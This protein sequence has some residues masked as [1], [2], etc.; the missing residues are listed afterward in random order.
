MQRVGARAALRP[1]VLAGALEQAPAPVGVA[2]RERLLGRV[3]RVEG[4]A[5]PLL[6]RPLAGLIGEAPRERDALDRALVRGEQRDRARRVRLGERRRLLDRE[7]RVDGRPRADAVADHR[8]DPPERGQR[9]PRPRPRPQP[10]VE[11]RV[12]GEAA[13]PLLPVRRGDRRRHPLH[14][15]RRLPLP[16]LGRKLVD[17]PP[18]PRPIVVG[19]LHHERPLV[20]RQRRADLPARALP[21]R[22]PEQA[23]P[24]VDLSPRLDRPRRA[25]RRL[26]LRPAREDRLRP[27]R[28]LR[29]PAGGDEP[30][31]LRLVRRALGLPQLR[32]LL[33]QRPAGRARPRPPP[34]PRAA[35]GPPRPCPRARARSARR[36][37]APPP[38]AAPPRGPPTRPP[39]PRPRCGPPRSRAAPGHRGARA[40]RPED[41]RRAPAP[42]RRRPSRRPGSAPGPAPRARS[43]ARGARACRAAPRARSR[44]PPPRG[45]RRPG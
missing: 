34:P 8:V 10:L 24:L 19:E 3:E 12:R 42:P 22:L 6:R 29:V 30:R 38:R 5:L 1:D 7:R 44:T 21:I 11:V 25:P 35:A 16:L 28:R 33:L 2:G 27:G 4:V 41:R 17:R 37:T 18:G 20:E 40:P 45:R 32:Q 14:L 23:P 31:E 9:I 39:G 43:A 36:A 13:G 26:A 15:P